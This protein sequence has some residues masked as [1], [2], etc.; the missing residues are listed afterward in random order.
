MV[1]AYRQINP[2]LVGYD[3]EK[4]YH[5]SQRKGDKENYLILQ[6]GDMSGDF[7]TWSEELP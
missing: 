6:S 2:V 1:G 5:G 7:T 4:C 3:L